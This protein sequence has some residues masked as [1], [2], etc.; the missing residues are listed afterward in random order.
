M[1]N[2]VLLYVEDED[3]AVF[4]LETAL[5]EAQ[6]P[7]QL[8]RVS[9]GEQALAFL[10]KAGAYSKAPR[11]DLILLD[12]NLPRMNG[13]EVLSEMQSHGDLR[14]IGVVVFTSSSLAADRRRSLSLGA[15]EYITKPSSFDGF[16]QAVRTACSQLPTQ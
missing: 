3:A 12:L 15:R 1:P 16:V 5:Q 14:S 8:Y 9:D 7:V 6:I 13:L 2:K 4:L 10:Q 11:P